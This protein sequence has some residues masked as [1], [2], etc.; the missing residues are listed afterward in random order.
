MQ[1]T[2]TP[3]TA[4]TTLLLLLCLAARAAGVEPPPPPGA[5]PERFVYAGVI[6]DEHGKALAGAEVMATHRS[7]PEGKSHGYIDV[8]RTDEDG[9]FSIDRAEAL[10]G[11][12]PQTLRNT[13]RIRIDVRHKDHLFQSLEGVR[14][15]SPEQ[16]RNIRVT[17]LPGRTI[18]GT[19]LDPAGEPVSGV[20]VQANFGNEYRNRK[21]AAT[22][23]A[24]RFEL[25]GV[26]PDM[27][28]TLEA[29]VTDRKLPPMSGTL[30]VAAL[31]GDDDD[32]KTAQAFTLRLERIELPPGTVVHDVLGMKLIDV[33]EPVRKAFHV[34]NAAGVMVLD[35]GPDGAARLDVGRLERG[36]TF[37]LVGDTKVK[38]VPEFKRRLL[39]DA[40]KSPKGDD[41]KA[42]RVVYSFDRLDRAGSNT[43]H[44]RLT[45]DDLESLDEGGEPVR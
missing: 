6:V 25:R 23:E 12:T 29:F 10:S 41:A 35:P 21:A 11:A 7:T 3:R 19:V 44:M 4:M 38:S 22:G 34:A 31:A 30:A 5:S 9:R 42:C 18:R 37:W 27:D 15:F 24:G 40:E 45:D 28:A 8:V 13:D 26:P 33:T 43:Q 20:R 14:H 17:L 32:P 39:Q 16:A 36:D 2:N 1:M